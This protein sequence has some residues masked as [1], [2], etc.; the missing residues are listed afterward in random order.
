VTWLHVFFVKFLSL[1]RDVFHVDGVLNEEAVI[2]RIRNDVEFRGAHAWILVTAILI[3]SLGL[4]TNS[5]AVIIGAMLISPLMSPIIGIGTALSILEAKLLSRSAKNLAIAVGIS[6]FTSTLYF[7]VTPLGDARSELI[8][9]TTPTLLDALIAIFGGVAGAISLIRQDRSNV[10]PGVAIAT[11]LMP[12]LCTA[13]FGLAHLDPRFFLGGFYLFFVNSVCISAAT[14][15]VMRIAGMHS[16]ISLD[17]SKARRVRALVTFVVIITLV[18]SIIIG[19]AIV[20]ES[21]FNRHSQELISDL[22]SRYPSAAIIETY[23]QYGEDSSKIELTV[24]GAEL[25][26]SDKRSVDTLRRS[27]GLQST[28]IMIRQAGDGD[29]TS[30]SGLVKEAQLVELYRGV[31]TMLARRKQENESLRTVYARD[32]IRRSTALEAAKEAVVLFR[33]MRTLSFAP[34]VVRW[35]ADRP[36]DTTSVVKVTWAS[37]PSKSTLRDFT[38]WFRV[39]LRDSTVVVE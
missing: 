4:N 19:Y 10:V 14:Y 6:L 37:R 39:R 11:A 18:P 13:G 30:G 7:L 28:S 2:R 32:S 22:R 9:R 34:S 23:Q 27:H 15:A 20:K 12:P 3:A 35:H 31:E 29:Q 38:N 25:S 33:N 1:I 17:P 26:E 21:I 16:H 8:S 5:T 36:P 24:V